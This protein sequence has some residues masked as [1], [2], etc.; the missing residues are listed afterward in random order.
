MLHIFWSNPTTAL[1]AHIIYCNYSERIKHMDE[2]CNFWEQQSSHRRK[3]KEW[4]IV[5]VYLV[6]NSF[7]IFKL[8]YCKACFVVN[9]IA[10]FHLIFWD[11]N[12]KRE[13]LVTMESTLAGLAF[14]LSIF[15]NG[16]Y[17]FIGIS[18]ISSVHF[19]KRNLT[20][21]QVIVSICIQDNNSI[22]D[23]LRKH[24]I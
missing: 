7:R 22:I 17:W 21:K 12:V 1:L 24:L 18:N 13:E 20:K 19:L 8:M 11:K 14:T 3:T 9:F 10:Y 16:N 4:G 2:E 15:Q 5:Y 6:V 23:K